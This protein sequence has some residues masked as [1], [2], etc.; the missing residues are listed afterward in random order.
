M[1][2]WGIIPDKL[3]D[4]EWKIMRKHTVVGY[5]ILKNSNREI[6]KAAAIVARDHHEKWDGTGYPRKTKENE[7]HI[8]G[9][10]TAIAD[11]FDAL[12]SDRCYKEAWEDQDIFELFKEQ[13]GKHFDPEL[14]E[15]FLENIDKFKEIRKRYKD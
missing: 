11:V 14:I 2:F 12:G 9:R 15:L 4:D 5:N 7:I 6:L 13:K 10:I 8:Y 1:T 3:N